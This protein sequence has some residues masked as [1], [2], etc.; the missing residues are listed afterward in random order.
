MKKVQC[1]GIQL[2]GILEEQDFLVGQVESSR[3]VGWFS[4]SKG[5]RPG[6]WNILFLIHWIHDVSHVG[7]EC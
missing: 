5:E 4:A 1:E 3:V 7:T 6:S 2:C